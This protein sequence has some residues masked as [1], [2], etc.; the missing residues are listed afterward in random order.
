MA[1]YFL[2][3]QAFGTGIFIY[4]LYKEKCHFHKPTCTPICFFECRGRLGVVTKVLDPWTLCFLVCTKAL[5]LYIACENFI[6]SWA[7]KVENHWSR[8]L[9]LLRASVYKYLAID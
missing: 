8:L 7:V 1:F 4:Q 6:S 5:G 9:F 2:L 3:S